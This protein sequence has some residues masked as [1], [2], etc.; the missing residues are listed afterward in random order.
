MVGIKLAVFVALGFYNRWWRYVSTKD[1]WR[2]ALGVL[3]ASAL[4]ALAASS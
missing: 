2:A 3:I 1:M 4:A